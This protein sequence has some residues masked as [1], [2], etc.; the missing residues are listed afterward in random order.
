MFVPDDLGHFGRGL[1][2]GLV[3]VRVT[4]AGQGVH[5]I[6]K[7]SP[8]LPVANLGHEGYCLVVSTCHGRH[9]KIG[10]HQIYTLQRTFGIHL[11]N[12]TFPHVL[13][14]SCPAEFEAVLDTLVT[15]V[16]K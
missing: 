2:S 15:G 8:A 5:A 11:S 6:V 13:S 1:A 16:W 10:D 9:T 7:H 4:R 14:L 12:I 3:I